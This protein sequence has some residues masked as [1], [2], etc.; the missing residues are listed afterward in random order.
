MGRDDS[1]TLAALKAHRQEGINIGDIIIDGEDI[2]GDGV[3]AA[4]RL[5]ALAEPGGIDVGV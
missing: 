5:R 3:N 1:A 2:Y 4:A